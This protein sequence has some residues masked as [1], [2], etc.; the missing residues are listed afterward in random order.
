MVSAQRLGRRASVTCTAP[1]TK[2]IVDCFCDAS[3]GDGLVGNS[4]VSGLGVHGLNLSCSVGG[5][6]HIQRG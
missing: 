3:V 6:S 4:G 5:V 1:M 2:P